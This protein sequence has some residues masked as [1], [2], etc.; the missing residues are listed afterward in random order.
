MAKRPMREQGYAMLAAVVAIAVLALMSLSLIDTGRGITVGVSAEAEHAR[1]AAAADA[2]LVIAAFHLSGPDLGRRW[3]IDGRPRNA[4]FAGTDLVITVEDE[5]G[6]VPINQLTDEQ[7]RSLFEGLGASGD[8]LSI[9]TD[10]FLDWL[11]EDDD[12][13]PDG[14]EVDYYQRLGRHP[15]NGLLRNVEE[16]ALIRGMT[17][18]L[19]NRLRGV[20]TAYRDER[21]GF[22]VRYAAPLALA[23][24]TGD[25]FGSPAVIDR[26][27][28]LAGQR[29]AIA[30]ATDESLVG[31]PLTVR[32]VAQRPGGGH[33]SRAYLIELTGRPD[34]FYTVRSID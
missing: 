15:R 23:I 24:M 3:T 28:E 34:T 17:P 4:R 29:P 27:R 18:D 32:I 14:A 8:T 20:A 5:R 12:P 22:D 9:R 6:K 26:E 1:L 33:F 21:D 7:A 19:V 31:R 25:G 2:G 13:R 11:D 16:L 30:L 10:A